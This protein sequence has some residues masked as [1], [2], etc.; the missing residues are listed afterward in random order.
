MTRLSYRATVEDRPLVVRY[1]EDGFEASDPTGALA[2]DPT[3]FP[4][5]AGAHAWWAVVLVWRR[6]DGDAPWDPDVVREIVAE[7]REGWTAGAAAGRRPTIRDVQAAAT[8][9]ALGH[10]PSRV[11]PPRRPPVPP[12]LRGAIVPPPPRT[13]PQ[14]P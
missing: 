14:A 2:D 3:R 12:A 13:P 11:A 8:R 1:T 9:R 6:R 7:A 5:A 4:G 10:F